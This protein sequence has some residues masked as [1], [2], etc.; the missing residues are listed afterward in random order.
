MGSRD[1]ESSSIINR[2]VEVALLCYFDF[3]TKKKTAGFGNAKNRSPEQA[4]AAREHVKRIMDSVGTQDIVVYTD[5][6][7][8]G[9]PGPSGSGVYISFPA[10]WN[11][12]DVHIYVSLG[13][14]TNNVGELFAIGAAAQH[15]YN[16]ISSLLLCFEGKVTEQ[17]YLHNAVNAT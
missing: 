4:A 16:L 8:H 1:D 17:G 9:N 5:G 3:K 6:S 11:L 2:I 10:D 15:I 12:E 14:S 13:R 7:S